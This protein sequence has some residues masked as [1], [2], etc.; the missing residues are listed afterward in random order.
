MTTRPVG[1]DDAGIST[2]T[3]GDISAHELHER[4]SVPKESDR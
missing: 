2:S 1:R 4:L 3:N